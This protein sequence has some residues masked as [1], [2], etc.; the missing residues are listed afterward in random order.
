MTFSSEAC[1]STP[2]PTAPAAAVAASRSAAVSGGLAIVLL[3]VPRGRPRPGDQPDADE[4][5]PV[6]PARP[7]T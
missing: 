1:G 2:A 3:A 6:V 7:M 5:G 4:T